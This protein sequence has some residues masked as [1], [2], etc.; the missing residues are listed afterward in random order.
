MKRLILVVLM[1]ALPAAASAGQDPALTQILEQASREHKPVLLDFWAIWCHPCAMMEHD[2][3]PKPEVQA[4][5]G[6]YV[7]QHYDAEVGEGAKLAEQFH[8]VAYPTLLILSPDGEQIEQVTEQ[9]P[10]ALAKHLLASAPIALATH[11]DDAAI[12]ASR[13]P[14]RLYIAA[15]G[16]DK[17]GDVPA[18]IALYQR[19]EASDPGNEASVAGKASFRRLQ[20]ETYVVE[21]K[22]HGEALI[23]FIETH[24]GAAE[25]NRAWTGLAA[26]PEWARPARARLVAA[27][28]KTIAVAEKNELNDVV[29]AFMGLGLMESA[30]KAADKLEKVAADD[31]NLL[32]SVAEVAFQSGQ[33]DRA[34]EIE[35]RALAK[36]PAS[37]PLTANLERFKKE[38]PGYTADGASDPLVAPLSREDVL[39]PALRARLAAQAVLEHA[40][41]QKCRN[42]LADFKDPVAVRV[43]LKDHKVARTVIMDPE[44]P[45]KLKTCVEGALR[46]IVEPDDAGERT[47]Y[48]LRLPA[49]P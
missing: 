41:A 14:R 29:Y 7:F 19:A 24:V 8:I 28:E 5:L 33:R 31:P 12:A 37:K 32:D 36:D 2:V 47:N 23:T 15:Q 4:A 20:L 3:F 11:M 18:A 21:T 30:Q 46:G 25:A 35:G 34:V 10:A 49:K 48:T 22:A 6:N 9:E 26:I 17:K 39:P 45:G 40:L 42:L 27:A 16:I 44:M 13:D 1:L 38:K 43:Y